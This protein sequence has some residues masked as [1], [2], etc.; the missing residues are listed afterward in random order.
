VQKSDWHRGSSLAQMMECGSKKHTKNRLSPAFDDRLYQ[1]RRVDL[2]S[3]NSCL[4]LYWKLL[5]LPILVKAQ[6][7]CSQ[8]EKSIESNGLL[9]PRRTLGGLK[10][11][12]Q[13]SA[14]WILLAFAGLGGVLVL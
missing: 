4:G 2:V 5:K 11:S 7:V 10:M 1:R 3:V 14:K 8:P 13:L 12:R 6:S 9:N